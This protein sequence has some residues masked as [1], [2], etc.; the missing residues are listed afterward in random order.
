M[1][2][3]KILDEYIS[4]IDLLTN[5]IKNLPEAMFHFRPNRKDAW[6]IKEHIIH[7]VDSE[8]NGFIRC[9]SIIAQPNT[10]CYV[11]NEESWTKNLSRKNEDVHKYIR[12]FKM[13]RDI[14]YDLLIDEPEENWNKNYFIRDYKGERKNITIEKCIE[15][16]NHHLNFHI[17]YIDKIIKESKHLS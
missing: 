10:E 11:M 2:Y 8:T 17:E 7:L 16:Y 1:K 15:L 12:L 13:I 9:K 14:V 4:R 6:T 3:K 5:R